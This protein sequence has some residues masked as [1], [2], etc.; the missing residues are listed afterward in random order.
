MAAATSHHSLKQLLCWGNF[1][2]S[3]ALIHTGKGS[4]LLP[5]AFESFEAGSAHD[6]CL[7]PF[8]GCVGAG[9]GESLISWRNSVH[10]PSAGQMQY[11]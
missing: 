6:M 3:A 10:A 11:S 2:C 5:K 9:A 7:V 4:S 8:L 1:L